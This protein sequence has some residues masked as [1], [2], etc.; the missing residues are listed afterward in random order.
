VDES[1][2][3]AEGRTDH[4]EVCAGDPFFAA[5]RRTHGECVEAMRQEE[6]RL[7]R[8]MTDR[9]REGFARGFHAPEYRAEIRRL[10]AFGVEGAEEVGS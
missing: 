7:G 2:S 3:S 5:G 9:E 8:K 10:M 6:A 1:K 4:P